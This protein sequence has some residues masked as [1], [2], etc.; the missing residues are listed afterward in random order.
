MMKRLL[1]ILFLVSGLS[2]HG[3][4]QQASTMNMAID[5]VPL[6]S[7][8]KATLMSLALPGLGQAYNKKY[9][10]IP[11]VYAI[12]A[13]PLYFALDQQSKFTDFKNAYVKRVDGDSTTVDTKYSIRFPN[14]QDLLSRIDFHRGNRD[15]LF[16]LTGVAY[17]LN[18]VDAAVDAHLFYFDVSDDLVGSIK[19]NFQYSQN[20]RMVVP[21]LT[22]SLKFAKK[23]RRNAF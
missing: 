6:H 3:L 20:Q 13:T 23:N 9:W 21:S 16:V 15:L 8:T 10:K 11:I 5:S 2:Y 7:P 14:E 18:I 19:P 22:L 4:A 1:L 12:I 17:A